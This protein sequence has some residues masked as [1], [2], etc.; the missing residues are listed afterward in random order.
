MGSN[1]VQ[2]S[3]LFLSFFSGL[4]FTTVQVVCITEMISHI[5]ISFSAVQ[6][7][8]L[9]YIHLYSHM[10]EETRNQLIFLFDHLLPIESL[11]MTFT[12]DGKRQR[13][14]LINFLFL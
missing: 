3:F 11:S 8:E 4:N 6:I 10:D 9:S 14:S 5:S 1:P 12:A 13:L 7:Y 2:A